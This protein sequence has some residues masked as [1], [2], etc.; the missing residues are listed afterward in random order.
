M[1]SL[2]WKV[3]VMTNEKLENLARL[4]DSLAQNAS[5]PQQRENLMTIAERCASDVDQPGK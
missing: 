1:S 5:T 2:Q 4:C 3:H